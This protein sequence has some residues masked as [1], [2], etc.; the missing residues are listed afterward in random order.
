MARK[1]ANLLSGNCRDIESCSSDE[2]LMLLD[3]A[4]ENRV[5]QMLYTFVMAQG[6]TPP[7][8]IAER[9]RSVHLSGVVDGARRHHHFEKISDALT[10]EG[11]TIIPLKGVWLSETVYP[12]IAMRGMADI[13]LWIRKEDIDKALKV[14]ESTGYKQIDSPSSRPRELQDAMLGEILL[15]KKEAPFVELHWGIFLGEWLRQTA[16]IDER[17]IRDRTLPWKGEMVRQLQPEDA[18][19]HVAVHLAVN[20]HMSESAL[21]SLFDLHMMRRSLEIDWGLVIDR[22]VSWRIATP[23]WFVL[24]MMIQLFGDDDERLLE[25]LARAQPSV[26]RGWLLRQFISPEG[27]ITGDKTT[28]WKKFMFLLLLVD[29]SGASLSLAWQAIWPD[30]TWFVLRYGLQEAPPWRIALQRLLHP[31]FVIRHREL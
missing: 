7:P 11:I 27:A 25:K 26:L 29:H 21:R 20:H 18:V 10:N 30:R 2:W 8:D 4:N 13:D 31:V 19:L 5:S 1:L 22:A 24:D 9:L 28:G 12:N 16:W 23:V 3:L 15:C 14:M 6:L 17:L